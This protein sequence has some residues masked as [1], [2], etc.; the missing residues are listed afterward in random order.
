MPGGGSQGVKSFS[1]RSEI[2]RCLEA[3]VH[4]ASA[5]D[6]RGDDRSDDRVAGAPDHRNPPPRDP[7]PQRTVFMRLERLK[8][9]IEGRAGA[10]LDPEH[11]WALADL[12]RKVRRGQTLVKR[13]SSAGQTLVCSN[14]GSARCAAGPA[15]DNRS[16]TTV[17]DQ[18]LT[19]V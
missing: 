17:F 13:G 11:R 16:L 9:G 6:H 10:A 3:L 2:D 5:P 19:N 4:V 12:L 14:A 8:T 18:C 15:R 7:P 1:N